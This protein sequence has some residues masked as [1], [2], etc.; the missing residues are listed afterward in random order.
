MALFTYLI[1]HGKAHV[2]V[3]VQINGI[4]FRRIGYDSHSLPFAHDTVV[5]PSISGKKMAFTIFAVASDQPLGFAESWGWESLCDEADCG[6]GH[7]RF[8]GNVW[9]K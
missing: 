7:L 2:N 9:R 1:L 6:G 8:W 5:I 4:L 3:A